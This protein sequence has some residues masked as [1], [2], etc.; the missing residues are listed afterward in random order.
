MAISFVDGSCSFLLNLSL[1]I[2]FKFFGV[3]QIAL[4]IHPNSVP[5]LSFL[6]KFLIPPNNYV[7]KAKGFSSAFARQ[8]NPYWENTSPYVISRLDLVLTLLSTGSQYFSPRGPIF[9]SH[10]LPCSH[11]IFEGDVQKKKTTIEVTTN[12][13]INVFI[14]LTYKVHTFLDTHC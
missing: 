9:S 2:Y 4:V 6:F 8:A 1:V 7:I 12:K 13:K 3:S 11:P 14:L 5:F 10:F